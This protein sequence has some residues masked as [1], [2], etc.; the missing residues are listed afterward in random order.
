MEGNEI[1]FNAI[2]GIVALTLKEYSSLIRAS[3]RLEAVNALYKN[4]PNNYERDTAIRAVLNI[5]REVKND[6]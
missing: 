6:E 5:G 3:E 2:D 1:S 4:I